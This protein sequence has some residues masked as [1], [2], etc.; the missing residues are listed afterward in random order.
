M[1]ITGTHASG[2]QSDRNRPQHACTFFVASYLTSAKRW[3]AGIRTV[4]Q[5]FLVQKRFLARTKSTLH[6][7]P[8]VGLV[9]RMSA[10]LSL[11]GH[12]SERAY[13]DSL[14]PIITVPSIPAPVTVYDIIFTWGELED[15]LLCQSPLLSFVNVP[16]RVLVRIYIVPIEQVNYIIPHF[17]KN[18]RTTQ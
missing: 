16:E 12:R 2:Y 10:P 8:K 9:I 11:L 6:K 13:H 5:Y 15:G 4:W 18:V 3:A 17:C 14:S 7:G 1:R